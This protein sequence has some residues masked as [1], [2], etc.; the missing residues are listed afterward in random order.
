MQPNT[1][2]NEILYNLLIDF[3]N[4]VNRRFDEQERR[5]QDVNT[6]I[7]KFE[8]ETNNRFDRFE[9][10]FD[11]FEAETNSRFDKLEA[12]FDRFEAETNSKFDR[13]EARFDKFEAEVTDRFDQIGKNE[14][15]VRIRFS[16]IG[17][18]FNALIAALVG[19]TVTFVLNDR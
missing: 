7:D 11:R 12:R 5:F 6:R 18:I 10:R 15:R 16:T 1:V 4:D 17:A 8:T 14:N 19:G 2:T 13:F 9:A 3:K